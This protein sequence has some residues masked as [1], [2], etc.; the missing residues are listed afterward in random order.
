M[1]TKTLARNLLL[2][3]AVLAPGLASAQQYNPDGSPR[4][5]Y[6]HGRRHY[7]HNHY[8]T[9]GAD[10]RRRANNG[11]AVGAVTGGVL[12]ATLGGGLGNT[13]LGAGAGAVAGHEIGKHTAHC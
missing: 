9:C 13:L 11:T 12:G 7:Y 3:A 1:T 8:R 2:V 4:Y 5:Y 6:S 10:R